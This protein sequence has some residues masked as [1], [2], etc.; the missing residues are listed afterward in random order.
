M[1]R[2]H[3]PRHAALVR[4]ALFKPKQ[5]TFSVDSLPLCNPCHT[6]RYKVEPRRLEDQNMH[7]AGCVLRKTRKE[8]N[9]F[10]LNRR[11]RS[12]TKEVKRRKPKG[13]SRQTQTGTGHSARP[14]RGGHSNE[15]IQ[16]ISTL[17]TGAGVCCGACHRRSNTEVFIPASRRCELQILHFNIENPAESLWRS[18]RGRRRTRRGHGRH[19]SWHWL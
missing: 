12:D 2:T 7:M 3:G 13:E 19:Q 4:K 6:S 17:G 16:G 11:S 14:Y 9:C 10:D 8:N 15:I 5:G 18:P 1:D